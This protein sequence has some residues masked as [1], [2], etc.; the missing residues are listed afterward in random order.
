VHRRG[1]D[2][3]VLIFRYGCA[4]KNDMIIKKKMSDTRFWTSFA[5]WPIRQKPL[6]SAIPFHPFQSL[7]SWLIH[8]KKKND[9]ATYVAMIVYKTRKM[10]IGAKVASRLLS[11]ACIRRSHNTHSWRYSGGGF[12]LAYVDVAGGF[13][14]AASSSCIKILRSDDSSHASVT[15]RTDSASSPATV[16]LSAAFADA[17]ES[18]ALSPDLSLELSSSSICTT[19]ERCS[20]IETRAGV[21]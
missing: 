4:V 9:W 2:D 20:S 5:P 7:V 8:V 21:R 1:Y 15:L 11:T 19:S 16:L 14:L 3:D 18:P 13:S 17:D 12:H 10:M 6:R